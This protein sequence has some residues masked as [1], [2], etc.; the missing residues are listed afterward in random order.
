M[1]VRVDQ[2]KCASSGRCVFYSGEVFDQDPDTG[3]AIVTLSEP[4]PELHEI[5]REAARN[6]PAAAISVED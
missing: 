1:K 4:P 5:V 3:L 2:N 6:C